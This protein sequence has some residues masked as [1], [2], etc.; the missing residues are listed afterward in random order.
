MHD[1]L[2]RGESPYASHGLYPQPGVLSDED[3]EERHWGIA[4]GFAWRDASEKTVVYTDLGVSKG[5]EY[6]IEDAEKK[7]RPVEYRTLGAGWEERALA[8]EAKRPGPGW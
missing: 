5:M 6:G 2:K 8:S 4:A 7:G 1:C 3:G